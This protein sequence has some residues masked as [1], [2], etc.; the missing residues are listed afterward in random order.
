M[1][2]CGVEVEALFGDFIVARSRERGGI[3]RFFRWSIGDI[4][5]LGIAVRSRHCHLRIS[6]RWLPG[7]KRIGRLRGRRVAR[8]DSNKAHAQPGG[9]RKSE[10]TIIG[11]WP[12]HRF[13]GVRR[14]LEYS[15][16]PSCAG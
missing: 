13:V 10:S 15:E 2:A 8:Q 4:R 11:I 1:V 12:R 9:V 5:G 14:S 3:G 16:L 7:Q 6:G